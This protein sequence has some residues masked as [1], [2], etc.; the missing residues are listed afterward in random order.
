M[1]YVNGLGRTTLAGLKKFLIVISAA[2]VLSAC[3]GE[4]D[5]GTPAAISTPSGSSDLANQSPEIS[6]VPQA[7]TD[8]GQDY[9][10]VPAAKDA[11]S[12]FLE[13]SIVNKPS[14]AQFSAET[15]ALTGTPA[16]SDV[17]ET[18]D[19]TITVSDGR[20]QRS[21]GPF[22]ILIRA[23]DAVPPTNNNAPTISGTPAS[24][25]DVAATYSFTP[26][27]ADADSD[28]L[29]FSVSN[30]PSWATFSTASGALSG[31]PAATNVGNFNNIVISVSDGKVTTSL[32][33]FA[34]SVKGP[35][36]NTPTISGTPMTSVQATQA[37]AFQ[38]TAS[39]ADGDALT[40]SI[41]NKPSWATFSA[42]NGRLS[43]TP[44]AAN[45][46]SYSNIRISVSDGKVSA[47]M[48]AFAITVQA[49]SNTA[50]KI[51]GTPA[52]TGKVG[53]AYSFKPTASDAEGDTLGYTIQ[54]RPTW[55]TFTTASGTL[56]GTPTAAGSFANII[57][58]VSDG[59][60]TAS[61]PA[62]TITVSAATSGTNKPPTISGTPA[63]SIKVG[64]SYSFQPTAA[65]PEGATL[66]FSIQGKPSWA[67]FS[68]SSGKLTGTPTAAGASSGVVISVSDGTSSVSLPSFTITAAT[69]TVGSAS[70]TWVAPT[71]NTDGSTL[72]N[73]AGY[74]IVYGNSS[75]ALD[76]TIDVTNPGL[77]SY[78]VDDLGAG[79]WYFAVKAYTSTNAESAISNVASKTIP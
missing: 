21:V 3:G 51:S 53:V 17:G 4:S 40:W 41:E 32:P 24:S 34:I 54:N 47:S 38:P 71:Q 70:L 46:G 14:W 61:L 37:Y 69:A 39:D 30:R 20:D 2:A 73:L 52:T 68:T 60:T 10:F 42:S 45:V 56:S 55:A 23:R 31:K 62:F 50:P 57:V 65:D 44:A 64:S 72:S 77:T 75:S 7:V 16:D 35:N 12:D 27:A 63:T 13:F 8:A 49:A 26:T 36:N 76:Q 28:K 48:A 66:A 19:I 67:T 15:G 18:S 58:S 9:S 22:N 74:R 29:R 59:K 25:V 33:A 1:R 6:G 11:D 79:T 43:G 78:V 5:D